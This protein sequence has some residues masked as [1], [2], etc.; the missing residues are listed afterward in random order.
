[1]RS[2][3]FA[4]VLSA[5]FAVVTVDAYGQRAQRIAFKRGAVSA[6]ISGTLNGYGSKRVYLIRVREGQTIKTKQTSGKPISVWITNPA[7]ENAN[8]MD[9][10]C[11]NSHNISPTVSGDY[12]LEIVECQ[13]ADPWKGTFRL[14]IT[15]R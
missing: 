7:G 11:H 13:K 5:A 9:L 3:I 8:D 12:R 4:L 1:M 2:L 15:V 6:T 10:S 14:L